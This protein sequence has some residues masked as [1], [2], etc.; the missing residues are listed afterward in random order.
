MRRRALQAAAGTTALVSALFN[1]A[2]CCN[3]FVV[4]TA[5][6][7]RGGM[8]RA[9]GGVAGLRAAWIDEQVYDQ[10]WK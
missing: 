5:V 4:H 3:A 6:P 10:R 9:R 8:R 7:N 2:L 1:S